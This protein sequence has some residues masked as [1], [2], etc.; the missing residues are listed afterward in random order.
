MENQVVI[1]ENDSMTI[2]DYKY[3]F[4]SLASKC[5]KLILE[6]GGE[7]Y[8][9]EEVANRMLKS[10]GISDVQTYATPT[11]IIVS[12]NEKDD[13]FSFSHRIKSRGVNL[14][15]VSKVNDVV[16]KFTDKKI[17]VTEA[18][19]MVG[20]IES[21]TGYDE[22]TTCLFAALGGGSFA[23]IFGGRIRDFL[24]AFLISFFSNLL[25][26]RVDKYSKTPY[27]SYI[28]SGAFIGILAVC[29]SKY[30]FFTS[31]D[32]VISGAIMPYVP[33]ALL[34]NGVRDLISGDLVSGTSRIFEAMLVATFLAFGVGIGLILVRQI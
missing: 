7:T 32:K 2:R 17:T 3:S 19:K 33:G 5:A 14:E 25:S 24:V 9:A 12:I 22:I 21:Y 10:R 20:D 34:T 27:L 1:Q 11:V 31:A 18:E 26:N 8:R 28:I 15:K 29:T 23:I 4:A 16:R 6:N 13:N 30:L